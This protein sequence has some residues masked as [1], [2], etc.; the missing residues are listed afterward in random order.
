[1]IQGQR[2]LADVALTRRAASAA[3]YLAGSFQWW[4]L[5]LEPGLRYAG[6]AEQ[7]VTRGMFEP[8]LTARV[9]VTDRLSLDGTVGR[10]SQMPSLPL[11]VSGFESFGLRDLGLQT[12][13][14]TSLG[15]EARLLAD[16]TLRV[17]GFY[18]WLWVS[19]LRSQFTRDV[20]DIDLLEMRSGRGYGA[21]MLLRLPDRGRFH[22][23]LAY[24]LSWSLRNFDGIEGASDWDQ[25]HIVNLLGST[26]LGHG[27]SVGGR[28][29]YNTGRPYPVQSSVQEAPNYVRLP[30]F[31]QID[32][33]A[34][35]R[36]LLDRAT[37]DFYVDLENV[38][39]TREVTA[40]SR[41]EQSVTGTP[42]QIGFRIVLPSIGVHVEW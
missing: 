34:D 1:M 20:T 32:L 25:R 4:R 29:H 22:G 28:F 36:V 37:V 33:R 39:L 18:Q 38:T 9:A 17:T 40:Y 6:Y 41:P 10:F 11:S 19:D 23:W 8:R 42:Q 13:T 2:S 7:G 24:T 15:V 5:S 35:K 30:P 14:Q 21:E 27:Y 16:A 12:S 26:R 31:W 3:A